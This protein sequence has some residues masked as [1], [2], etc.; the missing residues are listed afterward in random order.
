MTITKKDIEK[1]IKYMKDEQSIYEGSYGKKDRKAQAYKDA[2]EY[3]E[4]YLL[5][6][7]KEEKKEVYV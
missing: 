6:K 3:L 4:S 5:P 1:C 2:A 7:V